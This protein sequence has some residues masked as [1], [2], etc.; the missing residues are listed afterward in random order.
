[1]NDTQITTVLIGCLTVMTFLAWPKDTA[2]TVQPPVI[3]VDNR[4]VD[5]ITGETLL[6]DYRAS[7]LVDLYM[8]TGQ[9]LEALA[10]IDTLNY[11]DERYGGPCEALQHLRDHG[12]Y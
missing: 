10:I 8:Q 11:V 5:M 6:E 12:D 2:V 3:L 9:E 7:C 1:M 4:Q